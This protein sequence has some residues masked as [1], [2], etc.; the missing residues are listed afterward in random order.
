MA[1]NIN[2]RTGNTPN[3][4]TGGP[5][6][7]RIRLDDSS[8]ESSYANFCCV[9]A[10]PEEVILEFGLHARADAA[11][12]PV[13]LEK[14]IVVNPFTAKRLLAALNASLARHEAVFGPVETDAAKRAGADGKRKAA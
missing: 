13:R 5:P 12:A 7:R 10:T 8:I 9:R 6:P 14:R 1:A 2:A 4:G 3:S 11:D